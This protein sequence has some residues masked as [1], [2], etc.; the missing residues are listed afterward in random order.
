MSAILQHRMLPVFG[1]VMLSVVHAVSQTRVTVDLASAY[2]YRGAFTDGLTLQP[3]IEAWG[4]GIPEKYGIPGV[5]VWGNYS[6]NS[7]DG[8]SA[9]SQFSEIQLYASYYL[10]TIL[11]G[12]DLYV[13]YTEYTYPISELDADKE[14]NVGIGYGGGGFLNQYVGWKPFPWWNKWSMPEHKVLPRATDVVLPWEY[15]LPTKWL[16]R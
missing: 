3:G 8:S 15:Q 11:D 6:L 4:L 2:Y 16:I 10:P 1:M 12:V 13:G 9:S 7:P 5:G 14:A